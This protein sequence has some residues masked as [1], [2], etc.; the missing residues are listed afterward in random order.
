MTATTLLKSSFPVP[1]LACLHEFCLAN[2]QRQSNS[3]K[4]GIA[5]K[6]IIII[7]NT[8]ENSVSVASLRRDTIQVGSTIFN[9]SGLVHRRAVQQGRK[10]TINVMNGCNSHS[11]NSTNSSCYS[12][13]AAWLSRSIPCPT[14]KDSASLFWCTVDSKPSWSKRKFR[15]HRRQHRLF[16]RHRKRSSF[17]PSFAP[18]P[19]AIP[20]YWFCW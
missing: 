19:S 6:F 14:K 13:L 10:A 4:E 16:L 20:S 1:S 5:V 12:S 15:D 2:G 7:R 17:Q 9:R 3:Q 8:A 18:Y 11:N